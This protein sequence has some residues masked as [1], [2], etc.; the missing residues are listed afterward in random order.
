MS[1]A[2][3]W[4]RRDLRIADNSALNAATANIPPEKMRMHVCWGN[5]EGPHDHDIALEK[6]IDELRNWGIRH[7][8]KIIG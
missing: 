6:V 5:Y 1:L 4:F 2:I 7:R 3:H 8:K